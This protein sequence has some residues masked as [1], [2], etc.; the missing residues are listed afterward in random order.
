ME[1]GEFVV[2]LL[3]RNVTERMSPSDVCQR[4]KSKNSRESRNEFDKRICES[5]EVTS[6]DTYSIVVMTLISGLTG[7]GKKVANANSSV[8]S[9]TTSGFFC[10]NLHTPLILSLSL[11]SPL[12]P[13]LK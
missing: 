5:F 8:R 10:Q 9:P 4:N 2:V 13:Y 11:P 7:S 12:L 6:E 1:R 3:L